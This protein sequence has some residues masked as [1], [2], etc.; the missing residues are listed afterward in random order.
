MEASSSSA[1]K[2][3]EVIFERYK[4]TWKWYENWVSENPEIVSQ[5]EK[6]FRV[7][8]YLLPGAVNVDTVV[9]EFVFSLSNL[10][11]LFHDGILRKAR[12][13][14]A[15]SLAISA[16]RLMQ[17][18][19]VIDH[20]E[21]FVELAASRCW[22]E[23]GRW[24]FIALIQI[25]R[26]IFRLILLLKH[27]AG[28]RSQPPLQPL[29]RDSDLKP[30]T[31]EAAGEG[32]DT[33][34]TGERLVLGMAGRTSRVTFRG[35]R[36]GRVVR[37]LDATPNIHQRT[38]RLPPSEAEN[39]RDSTS[40]E[41]EQPTE[42]MG[43]PLA[44]ESL[45][46]ARPLLHLTALLVW[47]QSSWKPWLLSLAADIASL[48]M[49]KSSKRYNRSERKELSNRSTMLLLYL[50]RSPCY[51]RYTDTVPVEQRLCAF[52]RKWMA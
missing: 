35:E 27:K 45:Q 44:G 51:D 15:P 17:W 43:F 16:Q 52:C 11:V 5:I 30:S 22:G 4:Q 47:G 8:S 24:F 33:S 50:L 48:Q 39:E 1:C 21:V 38:W 36:S 6:T 34:E 42:L 2:T 23:A 28:V 29:N 46:I 13:L 7:F 37:S 12:G 14:T 9:A 19:T 3:W 31:T 49:L 25:L 20:T 41:N 10:L 40:L 18:L 32:A 26:S